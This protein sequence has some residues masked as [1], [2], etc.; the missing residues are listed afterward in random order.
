MAQTRNGRQS[1]F[2]ADKLRVDQAIQHAGSGVV[3]SS[4]NASCQPNNGQVILKK[5]RGEPIQEELSFRQQ[6]RLMS[7]RGQQLT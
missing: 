3:S 1:L 6:V 4:S 7:I 5:H 2:D